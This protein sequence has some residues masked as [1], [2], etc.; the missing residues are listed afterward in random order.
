MT[1]EK[2]TL[3]FYHETRMKMLGMSRC[4]ERDGGRLSRR[5]TSTEVLRMLGRRNEGVGRWK[6]KPKREGKGKKG[7]V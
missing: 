5:S 2:A 4:E 3:T 7:N 6:K 1:I